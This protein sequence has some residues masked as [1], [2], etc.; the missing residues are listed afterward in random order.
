MNIK[1][2][3]IVRASKMSFQSSELYYNTGSQRQKD[4]MCRLC[5]CTECVIHVLTFQ[6]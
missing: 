1:G 2:C 4:D 5:T 6:N 3:P